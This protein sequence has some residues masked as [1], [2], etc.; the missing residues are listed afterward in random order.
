[1]ADAAFGL[2]TSEAVRNKWL[3]FLD[4][5]KDCTGK[6]M[7]SSGKANFHAAVVH[8][9]KWIDNTIGPVMAL[10]HRTM[11]PAEGYTLSKV[12][13]FWEQLLKATYKL[14][15]DEGIKNNTA[16]KFVTAVPPGQLEKMRWMLDDTVE[17]ALRE[18]SQKQEL[19]GDEKLLYFNLLMYALIMIRPCRPGTYAAW[20]VARDQAECALTRFLL[21]LVARTA[22]STN[23][24]RR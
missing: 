24:S 13:K 2:Y 11:S 1:M 8:F 10:G 23:G 15:K 9:L 6:T 14:S 19:T 16:E 4:A 3:T 18:L 22:T 21:L 12:L 5:H 20:Y 17:P 7:S